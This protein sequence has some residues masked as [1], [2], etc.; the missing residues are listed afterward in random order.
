MLLLGAVVL[1]AAGRDCPAPSSYPLLSLL[2]VVLSPSGL[3]RQVSL[4]SVSGV[5]NCFFE[6]LYGGYLVFLG[7]GWNAGS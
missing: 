2:S 6:F 3:Q 4:D 1:T 7:L 5:Q